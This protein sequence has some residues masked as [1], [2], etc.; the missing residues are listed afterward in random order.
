MSKHRIGLRHQGL[1]YL[2]LE[3]Y[4]LPSDAFIYIGSPM[5][6]PTEFTALYRLFLRATSAAVLHN[7]PALRGLRKLYRPSFEA[8]AS[9]VRQMENMEAGSKNAEKV[10]KWLEEFDKRSTIFVSCRLYFT[11]FSC[12][13]VSKQ[14]TVLISKCIAITRPPTHCRL[15][16]LFSSPYK[17]LLEYPS[18]A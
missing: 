4:V 6:L 10:R 5:A 18:Q 11:Y 13:A 16:S 3:I 17:L 1:S 9:A 8:A 14:Y 2:H 7:G 15:A 12:F